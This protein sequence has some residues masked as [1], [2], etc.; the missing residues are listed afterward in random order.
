M[1]SLR[2]KSGFTFIELLVVIAILAVLFVLVFVSI[3]SVQ[4]KAQNTR[5]RNDVRQLRLLAEQ[6]FDSAGANFAGWTSN[7]L[8][9]NN[10]QILRNDIAFVNHATTPDLSSSVLI[11]SRVEEYCISAKLLVPEDGANYFCVDASATFHLTHAQCSDPND[12]E[13]PLVCPN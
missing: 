12:S 6:V 9:V 3:R 5:I 13:T 7:P 11:D 4:K 2:N 1:K 8:I 10:I